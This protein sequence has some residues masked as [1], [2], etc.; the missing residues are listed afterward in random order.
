MLLSRRSLLAGAATFAAVASL[1]RLIRA[2][3][4][5]KTLRLQTRQIE[6]GGKPATRYGAIQPSGAFG[7][8]LDEGDELD[9]VVENALPAPSGLHW[10]GLTEP[11]RL[12]GVPYLS[13]PPIAPGGAVAYCFPAIPTGTR[14]MHSH[15]GLQE[16]DLLAAPLI[17][18]E[19]SAAANGAQEVVLLLEDFSWTDSQTLYDNLRKPKV[20]SMDMSENAGPDLND[21]AYDA[22][23]ANDRT[24]DD[25]EVIDVERNGEVRLR[26]INAAAST[27]FTV[28]LGG[29]EG[30]L[31]SVDGNPVVP[32]SVR[33]LPLAVAQRADIVLRM[34]ADGGAVPVLAIG[35]GRK[36]RTGIVLRPPGVS[37]TRVS[38]E[39]PD[40]GPVVGLELEAGLVAAQPLTAKSI[41]NSI[42][43]DLTGTMV[44]YIWGMTVNDQGG[45]PATIDKGQRVELVMRNRTKMAHPMH[46]HG[47]I[48]QVVESLPHGRR[49]VRDGRLPVIQ[50]SSRP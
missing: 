42:P 49:H 7:L 39:A 2:T 20:G 27:N 19:K 23:I 10:H 11:W 26:I 21:V 48:F 25:P 37:V 14:F 47:H 22:F 9:V 35:E 18:R 31:V 32:L 41:D 43:V 15:F 46:L 6:V 38:S 29:N 3:E 34:P 45:L 8:T 12:D 1:P 16:Q 24:L 40:P 13:A 5:Q 30:S 50:L 36:L 33:R 28:D 4:N 44:G 17:I